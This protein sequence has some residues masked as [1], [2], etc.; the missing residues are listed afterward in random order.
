M[1]RWLPAPGLS[2]CIA[3]LWL[4]LMQSLAVAQLLFALCLAV[5]IPKLTAPLQLGNSLVR[6]P[7][8]LLRLISWSLLEI[9][10]SSINVSRIILFKRKEEVNSQFIRVPLT[11]RDST[12]LAI[13]SCL[14]NSTPGTVWIEILAERHE[15]SLH[16]FD[17]HDEDWWIQTI[18]Q[19]YEQPLIAIF[20][21][22]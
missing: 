11:L 2:F 8:L 21:A 17:L 14:I 10:R 12:G 6:K 13:L 15:L 18:Q 4:G 1:N 19:R 20:E 16:V 3:L 9:I 5:I 22:P 7:K